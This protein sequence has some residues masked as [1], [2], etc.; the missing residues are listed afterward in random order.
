M[1]ISRKKCVSF[2]CPKDHST[3]KLGSQVE[4]CALQLVN[5]QKDRQTD[6][7]TDTKVNTEGTRSGFQEFFLQTIIIDQP[8][9]NPLSVVHCNLSHLMTQIHDNFQVLSSIK[10]KTIFNYSLFVRGSHPH[11]QGLK[12][13]RLSV[14]HSNLILAI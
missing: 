4:K 13:N 14:V 5:R 3:Q 9:N 10:K 1:K 6:R 2:S 8:K 7:Q 11:G 12:T